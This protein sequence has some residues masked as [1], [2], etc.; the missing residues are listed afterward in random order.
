M[1]PETKARSRV[2]VLV[3]AYNAASTLADVLDRLPESFRE[4]VDHILVCDDAS[5]DSTYSIGVDYKTESDLP[6]TIIRHPVN[7][8]Y[9]GNQ[10]AGYRWAIEH[11]LDIVVL[12]HGDGQYSPEVIED[13][14]EPLEAGSCDA[15]FGSRMMTPGGALEG[16]M[17][18]YK[19]VGNRI[20]TKFE[21]TLVGLELTEWHSGYRAYRTDALQDLPFEGN[22]DGFDFDTEIILQLH[23]A[24]KTILEV[25]IPTYYGGE[26]CHV[27]GMKYAWD[28]ALDV[29]K[30]RMHKLGFGSRDATVADDAYDIKLTPTSSHGRLLDWMSKRPVSRVLDVGCSDGKFGALLKMQGHEV[31]GLDAVTHKGVHERLDGFI[32]VDLNQGLPDDLGDNFD[33]V[34]AADVIEHTID[35]TRLLQQLREKLTPG[36]VL[37]ASVPNFAHWYPRARVALGRFDYDRRGI[38]DSGHVR[39]FTRRSFER[40]VRDAGYEVGRREAVGLPFEVMERGGGSPKRTEKTLSTIDRIGVSMWP[41]MFGYQFLYQLRPA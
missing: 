21:N 4:R 11:G 22:S 41:T 31:V 1:T 39:F 6:L 40:T 35:P 28:V 18:R 13:L 27:N 30:Y 26:I 34:L 15:V 24:G 38:L 32:E 2:G 3:V 9:G 25:P 16:G 12:L 33:V 8:G 20:L 7:L 29:S 5:H 36:G 19:Y 23:E 17:P 10:K 37:L 14:V